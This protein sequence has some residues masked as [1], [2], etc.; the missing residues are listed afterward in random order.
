[1]CSG[2]IRRVATN[3]PFFGPTLFIINPG[4]ALYVMYIDNSTL[5]Y[6][7]LTMQAT[8]N[9]H[10]FMPH[11]IIPLQIVK[12]EIDVIAREHANAKLLASPAHHFAIL[13]IHS[14][15]TRK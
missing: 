5:T 8:L 2:Q 14:L 9:M 6:I 13:G 10:S 12:A 1:M 7:T 11:L 4:S 15:I 3:P